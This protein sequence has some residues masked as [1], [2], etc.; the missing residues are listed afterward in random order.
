MWQEIV[1]RHVNVSGPA[2]HFQVRFL[3]PTFEM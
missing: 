3:R 2:R 1:A